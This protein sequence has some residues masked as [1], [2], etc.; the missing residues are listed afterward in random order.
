MGRAP[1][2]SASDGLAGWVI[3]QLNNIVKILS[4]LI[5]RVNALQPMFSIVFIKRLSVPVGAKDIIGYRKH[6]SVHIPRTMLMFSLIG[7]N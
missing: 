5:S 2:A 4:A 6:F 3:H 1:I 7:L